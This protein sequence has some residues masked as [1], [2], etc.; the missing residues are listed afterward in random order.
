MLTW[1][2]IFVVLSYLGSDKPGDNGFGVNLLSLLFWAIPFFC[3][4]WLV[5]KVLKLKRD[6]FQG[7]VVLAGMRIGIIGV[8]VAAI[9][10]T[11]SSIDPF[12]IISKNYVGIENSENHEHYLYK[13]DGD[14][15]ETD[16]TDEEKEEHK[17]FYLFWQSGYIDG[18]DIENIQSDMKDSTFELFLISGLFYWIE[19][20]LLFILIFFLPYIPVMII[21]ALFRKKLPYTKF[22][23]LSK[24][25]GEKN[26]F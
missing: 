21:I 9:V 4:G 11:I 1:I 20:A 5:R 18:F 12:N 23:E 3:F 22:S 10:S 16:E 7:F 26:F 24:Y 19:R 13:Y 6:D 14:L 17:R 25:F 2:V 15:Y 8:F